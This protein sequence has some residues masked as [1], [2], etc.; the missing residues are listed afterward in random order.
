MIVKALTYL[1]LLQ[2]DWDAIAAL[3]ETDAEKRAKEEE[4]FSRRANRVES[5]DVSAL[6]CCC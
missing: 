4:R 3:R 6:C 2:P 5:A 1:R